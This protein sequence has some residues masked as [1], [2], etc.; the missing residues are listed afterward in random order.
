MAHQGGMMMVEVVFDKGGVGEAHRHPHEQIS[1]IA[2]GKFAFNIE[3][4]KSVVC[5][6]DSIYIPNSTTLSKATTIPTD[7]V[8]IVKDGALLSGEAGVTL[9]V[10]GTITGVTGID[11]PG[12]YTWTDGAWT[13]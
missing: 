5:K 13:K 12:T 3:G 8:V 1:Y 7:V 2:K 11:G 9:T 6:G 4:E 10:N